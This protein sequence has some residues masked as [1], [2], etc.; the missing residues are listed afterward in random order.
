M[1][2]ETGRQPGQFFYPR[3]MDIALL[4]GR[5]VLVVVDKTARIQLIDCE[6]GLPLGSLRTPESD[7]G[8]PTG[9]TVAPHPADPSRPA[10]WVADT[11]EHR[12]L[13]YP[14]PFDHDG[15][16]T[17]P[18]LA[19]GSYGQEPGRFI[20]P[21]D[22]AV[23][24]DDQGRPI[25]VFVSEYGG[26]DRVSVFAV[27]REGDSVSFRFERQIGHSGVAMDAPADDPSALS[28]PQSV[29][30][31][32]NGAELVVTDAGRHRVVRFDVVTGAVIGW[33]DGTKGGEADQGA[34]AG[35]EAEQASTR[36]MRFPYGL[37]M[38]DDRHAVVAEFGA[39]RVR[40]LDLETGRT[41]GSFGAPGR[42]VGQLAT[43]W[44]C[45]V[46]DGELVVLDSGN[47]RV[48]VARWPGVEALARTA[49]WM[50]GDGW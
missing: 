20:Y 44:A 7:L 21:T 9:L 27:V 40:V 14:L 29:C 41:I 10:L 15:R 11:H 43:P 3:G 35:D 13:V 49:G 12:V 47:D 42:A 39:S 32:K 1:L 19:F 50:G 5:R 36:A 48:Q 31:R 45:L 38:V 22:V 8:M 34:H 18:D 23:L 17:E 6:T 46:S 4:G 33:T 30:L 16:P 28:R 25:R 37:S 26:N 24:S 2:G